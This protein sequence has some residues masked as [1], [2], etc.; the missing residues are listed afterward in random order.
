M[1]KF[2][3]I[4]PYTKLEVPDYFPEEREVDV[5]IHFRVSEDGNIYWG[6]MDCSGT[7]HKNQTLQELIAFFIKNYEDQDYK[8]VELSKVFIDQDFLEEYKAYSK[9]ANKEE[10]ERMSKFI[11]ALIDDFNK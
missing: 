5:K 7:I 10:S 1:T 6:P 9:T 11:H 2:I 8:F 4:Q 3:K